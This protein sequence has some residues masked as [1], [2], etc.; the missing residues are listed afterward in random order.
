[1]KTRGRLC[2]L[3]YDAQSPSFNEN[4]LPMWFPVPDVRM[5]LES[6]VF[7]LTGLAWQNILFSG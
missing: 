3:Q 7:A 1:M 5:N 2:R 4:A 6:E